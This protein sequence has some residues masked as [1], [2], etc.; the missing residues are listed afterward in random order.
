MLLLSKAL[1]SS[2]RLEIREFP[3]L[4]L[5]E[6]LQISMPAQQQQQQQQQQQEQ[7]QE[8]EQEQ[9]QQEQK[10]EQEQG[11]GQGQEQEE[12]REQEEEPEEEQKKNQ[13]KKTRSPALVRRA[14]AVWGMRSLGHWSL[15]N[16]KQG[17]FPWGNVV[18][19]RDLG[20]EEEIHTACHDKW[21]TKALQVTR[22]ICAKD[23][24]W[25]ANMI[26]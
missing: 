23:M 18:D 3:A 5:G 7:E 10:Q 16:F 12:E 24:E 15:V 1:Q 4:G 6:A 26:T 11:Q 20:E 25:P 21:M 19:L 13:N 22:Q 9:G 14:P 17:L 8:Q 2:H